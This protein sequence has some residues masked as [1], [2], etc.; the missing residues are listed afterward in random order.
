MSLPASL[1]LD[2][3]T[4]TCHHPGGCS[5]RA[6]YR[7]PDTGLRLCGTHSRRDP[8]RT[9]IPL[10]QNQDREI[11]HRRTVMR[12]AAENRSADRRG[13]VRLQTNNRWNYSPYIDGCVGV[14]FRE[15]YGE[16]GTVILHDL[17]LENVGP[18]DFPSVSFPSLAHMLKLCGLHTSDFNGEIKAEF[19]DHL[20]R[21]LNRPIPRPRITRRAQTLIER[22][23]DE[24]VTPRFYVNLSGTGVELLTL[25]QFR[26]LMCRLYE[27]L[28][29][30]STDIRDLRRALA[31][32]FNV[33]LWTANHILH[34][35]VLA[36]VIDDFHSEWQPFG[37]EN[38]VACMLMI[39]DPND[40]PWNVYIRRN[41]ELFQ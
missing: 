14:R 33:V 27:T 7:S 24:S 26:A 28:V 9:E 13:S 6:R 18:V 39:D 12:T 5:F 38:I 10:V 1:I 29:R 8:G 32:G 36:D 11:R 31:E 21:E 23:T 37:A 4:I 16:D 30:T 25:I 41:R 40:Y 22:Y 15:M 34:Q 3:E 2:L 19:W 20:R 35:S 17:A